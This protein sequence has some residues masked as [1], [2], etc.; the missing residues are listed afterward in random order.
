VKSELQQKLFDKY[1]NLFSQKDLSMRETCMCWGCEC[2]DGWYPILWDMCRRIDEVMKQ[3][4]VVVSFS[5][6][7]EKYGTL[8]VYHLVSFGDSWERKSQYLLLRRLLKPIPWL[9]NRLKPVVWKYKGEDKLAKVNLGWESAGQ[10]IDALDSVCSQIDEA[11]NLAEIFSSFTCEE[12]GQ[13]FV[14]EEETG[15]GCGGFIT[16]LCPSCKTKNART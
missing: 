10:M 8:R 16:T 12:C 14:P 5:Q 1:P 2:G 9:R 15:R 3:Y 11:I 13:T 4:D 6:V 7:K